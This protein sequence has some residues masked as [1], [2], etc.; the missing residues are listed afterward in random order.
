MAATNLAAIAQ[1]SVVGECPDRCARLLRFERVG[2]RPVGCLRLELGL[3]RLEVA[4]RIAVERRVLRVD[5]DQRLSDHGAGTDPRKPLAVG[6]DHI[7]GRPPGAGVTQHLRERLLVGIPGP[8]L[9]HIVGRELPV[10]LGEVD[11]PQ[12]ADALLLLRE[13]E[14]DLHDP[15][16]VPGEIP[17]PVVDRFVPAFPDVVLARLGRELLA[18]EVLGMHTDDQHLLVVGPVEDGDLAPRRQPFLV[19]AKEV[20]IELPRGW[21]LEALDPHTLGVDATH[22]MPNR[23]VL[24][25]GVECLEHHEDAVRVL[26]RE[27]RLVLRKQLDAVLQQLH[28][29]RS[30]S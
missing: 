15:K 7:P 17:L 26:R 29:R 23:P 16:A 14:E 27:P 3:C 8:A 24:A 12:E 11:A 5:V 10:V 6:R 30:S 21:D 2:S 28:V 4:Q 1:P 22:H 25:C 19:A 9:L 18:H 20:L 13:V